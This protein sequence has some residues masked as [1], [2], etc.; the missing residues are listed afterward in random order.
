MAEL[1]QTSYTLDLGPN[2]LHTIQSPDGFDQW[3]RSEQEFWNFLYRPQGMTFQSYQRAFQQLNQTRSQL[4]P[5]TLNWDQFAD[6]V[7]RI[8]STLVHSQ[9]EKGR[10][11][12]ALRKSNGDSIA[13][14]ATAYLTR[15]SLQ[16]QDDPDVR[17]G[18]LLATHFE[19]GLVDSGRAP[20]IVHDLQVHVQQWLKKAKADVDR[21][22]AAAQESRKQIAD[23]QTRQAGVVSTIMAEHQGQMGT[24]RSE[25]KNELATITDGFNNSVASFNKGYSATLS[26]SNQ[27]L[28]ALYLSHQEQL[29]AIRKTYQEDMALRSP[30]D[31]WTTKK[32]LHGDRSVKYAWAFA[33][34]LVGSALL[35][36]LLI[37]APWL[38]EP[39]LPKEADWSKLPLHRIVI[40][41]LLITFCVWVIRTC[42][43]LFF[44]NLHLYTDADE[45]V[46]MVKTY[47]ALMLEDKGLKDDD[48]R[49]VIETLFRKTST[50]IVDDDANPPLLVNLLKRNGE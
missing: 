42:A 38:D 28:E 3:V 22:I 44:S 46:V 23:A 29:N 27:R 13:A 2:G 34:S 32:T 50:G 21:E 47:L 14:A 49:L 24:L 25:H 36:I 17:Q 35:L 40:V 48:R 37:W 8:F 43:R 10:F 5:R 31:Y 1:K 12:A 30:V 4:D 39:L 9:S 16:H 33:A 15:H 41:A 7:Q 45:R 18:C 11:V 26:V 19:L 6:D 20:Q